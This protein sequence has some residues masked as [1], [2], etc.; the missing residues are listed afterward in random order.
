[1]KTV[2]RVRDVMT[3]DDIASDATARH[4]FRAVLVMTFGGLALLLAMVG[5]FGIL[6]YSAQQRVRDFGVRR[7]LGATTKDVFRHVVGN[8]LRVMATGAI[9][10]FALSIILGRLLATMLYG[11]AYFDPLTLAFVIITLG[12][13]AV[14]TAGPAWRA[15]RIDPVIALRGE[16]IF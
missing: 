12:L 5:V 14:S 15:C 10:G 3:L 7:T 13:M 4:R 2:F 6:A 9:I 1:M 11:V 16:W 8:A